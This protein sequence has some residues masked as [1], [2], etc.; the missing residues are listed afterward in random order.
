MVSF[1]LLLNNAVKYCDGLITIR[2]IGH[3]TA[4]TTKDSVYKFSQL[5]ITL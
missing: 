2:A 5:S 4:T 1:I 3:N